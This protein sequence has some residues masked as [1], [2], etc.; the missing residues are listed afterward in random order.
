MTETSYA[1]GITVQNLRAF[2]EVWSTILNGIEEAIEIMNI[3]GDRLFGTGND[4][5]S[6]C[7][8][9]ELPVRGLIGKLFSEV[10]H[11]VPESI[12]SRWHTQLANCPGN[13]GELPNLY[14]EVNTHFDLRFD[15][16]VEQIEALRPHLSGMGASLI[17]MRYSFY[18]ILYY[19]CYLN[20]LI[21]R[22]RAGDD[23]ALFSAIRVDPTVV[24]CPSVIDRI[25]KARRL[26]DREFL[27]ELRK[28]ESG[29]SDKRKQINFQMMRLVF[30]VLID[31]G[32]VRLSDEQLHE[33][34]V[35]GLKLYAANEKGGGAEKALR[36]HA[37]TYMKQKAIT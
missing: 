15:P 37:D 24:G 19:G 11:I 9:Y 30:K 6:W 4:Q 5:F 23:E 22:A 10:T 28:T 26:Q 34:F 3:D 27:D 17:A 20:E 35:K 13:I 7:Y 8:L 29:V 31:A 18:S 32:A 14:V 12:L 25:S 33:L 21:A 1:K 2:L 16:D 36:K